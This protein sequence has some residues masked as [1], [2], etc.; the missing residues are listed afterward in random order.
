VSETT[1]PA[2]GTDG[3]AA[4]VPSQRDGGLAEGD[5][6]DF[7]TF[8]REKARKEKAEKA[9]KEADAKEQA[10]FLAWQAE[11]TQQAEQQA[12]AKKAQKSNQRDAVPAGRP[13][14]PSPD[15]PMKVARVLETEWLHSDGALKVRHWRESWHRWT[16]SYWADGADSDVRTYMYKRT[17]SAGYVFV[18]GR[19]GIKDVRD[20]APTRG[21]VANL[22]EAF[23]AVANLSSDTEPGWI[24]GQSNDRLVIPC[25]NGLLDVADRRLWPCTPN[26][27]N[28]SAVPFDFDPKAPLPGR[29]LSFLGSVWPNDQEAIDALQEWFGY[30]LSG[31]RHLEKILSLVGP[32]RSG[33]GTISTVLKCLV[34]EAHTAGPTLASLTTNFGLAPLLGKSL[35]IIPDAR[36]PREGV[37]LAI[38]KLLMISGRDPVT[39]DRKHREPWTGVLPVQFVIMSNDL[40]ALPDTAA[41]IAGRMFVLRMTESFYGREDPTLKDD[42]LADLPGILNWAL[43]GLDRLIKRGRFDEPESSKEAVELLHRSSS[44]LQTFLQE[45][46][47]LDPEGIVTKD[48]LFDAWRGW[49]N[50]EG[51]DNVGTKE[52]F[53]RGLFSAAP[54]I[55]PCRPRDYP[56]GPQ[57]PSYQGLRLL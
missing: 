1:V 27:F 48:K 37:E 39:V 53:S 22:M 12:A 3:A 50:A 11:R 26:Y 8:R 52:T 15:T 36:K 46:C 4:M 49:C 42:V 57:I 45:S 23:S 9:L 7:E 14:L 51:R 32:R 24:N 21:K 16:G 29:W 20:W 28:T 5:V 41:A 43:D 31:R 56:G 19:S 18:D 34:G 47:E 35:A 54:N 33:K 13:L 55:K 17:E 30:I 2:T 6:S 44:P 10:E 25:R 38:E 40:L